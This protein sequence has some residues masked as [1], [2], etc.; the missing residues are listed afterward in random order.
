[1]DPGGRY[2]PINQRAWLVAVNRDVPVQATNDLDVWSIADSA[3]VSARDEDLN[4]ARLKIYCEFLAVDGWQVEGEQRIVG[5][6]GRGVGL[7]AQGKSI[8]HRFAM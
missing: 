7:I 4:P 3:H 8:G 2:A 1:M 6:G 5:H